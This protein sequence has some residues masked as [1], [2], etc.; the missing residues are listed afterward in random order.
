MLIR[1]I[2]RPLRILRPWG[3]RNSI[4]T[5]QI[6]LVPPRGAC[7]ISE[8]SKRMVLCQKITS[9]E[10]CPL[11]PHNNIWFSG[12]NVWPYDAPREVI[13]NWRWHNCGARHSPEATITN[14][15]HYAAN[16]LL[17]VNDIHQ[18]PLHD[19]CICINNVPSLYHACKTL[20]FACFLINHRLSGGAGYLFNRADLQYLLSDG[21]V[22][23][24]AWDEATSAWEKVRKQTFLEICLHRALGGSLCYLNDDHL[25]VCKA[26]LIYRHIHHCFFSIQEVAESFNSPFITKLWKQYWWW[27]LLSCISLHVRLR[28]YSCTWSVRLPNKLP[29]FAECLPCF[30]WWRNG[31]QIEP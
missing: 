2:L 9:I 18:Q 22:Q 14:E 16:F 7:T 19:D 25:M 3:W 15:Q 6:R 23:T 26:S 4:P 21:P 12:C 5:W 29:F 20:T 28:N 10:S 31:L 30:N 11:T 17:Q 24:M 8:S 13:G 1:S 27:L